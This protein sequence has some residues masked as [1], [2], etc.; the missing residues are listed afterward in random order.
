MRRHAFAS[1]IAALDGVGPAALAYA[2]ADAAHGAEAAA[3]GAVAVGSVHGGAPDGG[4]DDGDAAA[5]AAGVIACCSGDTARNRPPCLYTFAVAPAG[6]GAGWPAQLRVGLLGQ[7]FSASLGSGQGL[8]GLTAASLQ[9]HRLSRRG[10][11]ITRRGDL[12]GEVAQPVG[13]EPLLP[14]VLYEIAWRSDGA[15]DHGWWEPPPDPPRAPSSQ[16]PRRRPAAASP[17]PLRPAPP[18]LGAAAPRAVGGDASSDDPDASAD[19]RVTPGG[20]GKPTMS[21]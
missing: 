4:G 13:L 21:C 19:G 14:C 5:A 2:G 7:P 16:Q 9:W 1:R 17:L 6:G 11:G 15:P 18:P 12:N 20:A 10:L 8:V 3:A